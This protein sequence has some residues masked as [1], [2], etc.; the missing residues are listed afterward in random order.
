MK[1]FKRKSSND[2]LVVYILFLGHT[3]QHA[4]LIIALYTWLYTLL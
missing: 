4:F 3:T 2:S 1:P